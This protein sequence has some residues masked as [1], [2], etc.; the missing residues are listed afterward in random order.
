MRKAVLLVN[1][2]SPD[3]PSEGDVRRFLREFLSDPFVIDL[4][5]FLRKVLLE[6]VIL[7]FRPKRSAAAYAKVWTREGSPL[8]ALSRRQAEGLESRTGLSVHLAMRY[9]NPSI[10]SAVRAIVQDGAEEVLAIP[11]FP[12]YAASSY[13]TAARRVAEVFRKSAPK[14][15]LQILPPFYAEEG[16]AQALAASAKPFLEGDFHHLLFSFHGIPER[17][18]KKAD[19]SG[20]HCL[21]SEDCCAVPH[22]C[23]ATC[24]RAQCFKT[25][26]LF[27]ARAGLAPGSWSVS[28]QSRLGR[29]RWL[30]PYTFERLTELAKE[31]P[32]RLLVL[33]PSFVTDCLETLGEIAQEGRDLYA[34]EGGGDFTCIPCLN[35]SPAFLDFLAG[36]VREWERAMR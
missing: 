35:D 13:H 7:P 10:E 32:G 1:L 23:H 12:Q 6:G 26:E 19:P 28:F 34:A 30:T 11:M 5:W 22:P 36:K 18:V 24:Y 2:G 27:A 8:V 29:G 3:S 16:Y 9:G 33:C 25:A 4:P 20:A 14:V 21:I 17:H 15:S 31:S